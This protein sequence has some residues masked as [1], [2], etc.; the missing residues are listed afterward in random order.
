[1]GRGGPAV[2]KRYRKR[3]GCNTQ[4][5]LACRV[6]VKVCIWCPEKQASLA[7]IKANLKAQL[8]D[9]PAEADQNR[10]RTR[11]EN[12]RQKT[13]G[14]GSSGC[15]AVELQHRDTS[16]RSHED[17]GLHLGSKIS[18]WGTAETLAL[19]TSGSRGGFNPERRTKKKKEQGLRGTSVPGLSLLELAKPRR[20]H[21]FTDC[22]V[23][24]PCP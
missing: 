11:H 18:A 21:S 19:D 22:L 6:H 23:K 20:L 2:F 10:M 16:T 12:W 15:D 5:P 17:S 14:W 9:R 1:M 24:V 8:S 3:R 13:G 7:E 4:K